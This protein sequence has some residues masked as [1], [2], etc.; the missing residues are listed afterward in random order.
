MFSKKKKKLTMSAE[1]A[2]YIALRSDVRIHAVLL[3]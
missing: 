1:N 2:S 3:L